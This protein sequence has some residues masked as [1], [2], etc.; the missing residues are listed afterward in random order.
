MKANLGWRLHVEGADVCATMWSK[1]G[2]DIC[3]VNGFRSR[4][5]AWMFIA[6]YWV[7]MLQSRETE[8]TAM[9]REFT[10]QTK[11]H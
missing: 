8:A 2:G 9:L 11:S 3:T 5:E 10:S 6:A 7:L 1:E 4:L